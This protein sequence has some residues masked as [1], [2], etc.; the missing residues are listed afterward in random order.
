MLVV[1]KDVDGSWT[2]RE[3]AGVLLARY[4]SWQA[5]HRFAERARRARPAVSIASSAGV[6]ARLHGRLSIAGGRAARSS[7]AQDG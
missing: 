1:G 3:S 5:A 4:A 7:G 6:P 2:V